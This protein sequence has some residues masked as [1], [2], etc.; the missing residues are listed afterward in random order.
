[1]HRR[2]VVPFGHD[3]LVQELDGADVHTTGGLGGDEEPQRPGQ[4]PGHDHLLLVAAGQR[5]G[6]QRPRTAC[7]RRTRRSVSSAF[8]RTF[9]GLMLMPL[10]KGGWS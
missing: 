9:A 6:G 5:A 10:A 1:M 7:G 2:A 8:S 4:L 3:P